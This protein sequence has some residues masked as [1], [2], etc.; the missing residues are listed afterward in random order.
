MTR[1]LVILLPP[2]EGKRPGGSGSPL[3]AFGPVTTALLAAM[4]AADPTAL[5]PTRTVEAARINSSIRTAPTMPAIERYDGVVYDAL[6]YATLD[7]RAREYIDT[8]V[9]IVSALFGPL[10][11]RDPIPDYVLSM[12]KLRAAQRW[13]GDASTA[14]GTDTVVIDLLP[15]THRKTVAYTNGL[16]IDFTF[17]QGGKVVRAGHEG[18][19][20]KG[21]YVRWL[22]ENSVT[23][24]EKALTFTEDG[25][26]WN[27]TAFH[28]A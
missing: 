25:Y 3:R 2:S 7:A 22:A 23:T 11:A 16:R 26:T 4:D 17:T 27:G 9:V 12:T 19:R 10:K 15:D 8:H 5:Y 18:K 6:G 14:F 21:A 28:R 24:R 20:I 1:R 13:R